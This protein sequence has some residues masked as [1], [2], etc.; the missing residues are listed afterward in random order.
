MELDKITSGENREIIF[1]DHLKSS[2]L[3]LSDGQIRGAYFP[4]FFDRY[5]MADLPEAGTE[6]MK[7]RM[8]VKNTTK[9]PIKNQRGIDF[10]LENNYKEVRRSKRMI[11]GLK[12]EWKAENNYNRIS[13]GLG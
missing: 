6:L 11:L 10:L 2:L 3:Y 4:G 8:R 5:I 9:I 7:L 12:R 13:G 1:R